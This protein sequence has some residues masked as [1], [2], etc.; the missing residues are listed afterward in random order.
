MEQY[1]QNNIDK[2]HYK[3][4]H[5]LQKGIIVMKRVNMFYVVNKIR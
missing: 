4:K 2:I 1:K 5:I 3:R